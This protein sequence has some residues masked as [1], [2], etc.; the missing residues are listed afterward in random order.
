MA[1]QRWDPLRDLMVLHERVH[2]LFEESIAR[3]GGLTSAESL[4][5]AAW[6]P[7]VDLHEEPGRFL[8][9]ADVPGVA[10]ASL[11]LEVNA[12]EMVIRGE[13]AVDPVVPR[14]AFLRKERPSGPFVLRL[15]VPDAVERAAIQA[16]QRDGVLEVVLPKKKDSQEASRLVVPVK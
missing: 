10:S 16:S 8:L 12:N 1:I 13:R 5:A 2:R 14:D 9:R 3:S 11:T 15:T 6:A 4:P 7:P